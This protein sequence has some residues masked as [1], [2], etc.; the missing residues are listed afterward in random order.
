MRIL[1]SNDDG[2]YARGIA[3][4][5]GELSRTNE[6][7]VVAPDME[8]SGSSHSVTYQVPL[9]ASPISLDVLPG[10]STAIAVTGTPA[11]CVKLGCCNLVDGIELVVSGINHGSNLGTDVLYSGTVS[12]AMEAISLGIPAIASSIESNHPKHFETAAI[13]TR[14]AVEYLKERPLEP[15]CLLNINVP[16]LPAD[17][18]KG[19]RYTGL[20]CSVDR[21]P[22]VE[23]VDPY[24]RK[25]YWLPGR[26]DMPEPMK[27]SDAYWVKRGYVTLT[28]LRTHMVQQCDKMDSAQIHYDFLKEG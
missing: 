8:R 10:A 20:N 7:T 22:Y 26:A 16:D 27:D 25:Y 28:I 21:R 13:V 19:A 14:N 5:C 15:G 6:V 11:D 4:L 9:L 2:I 18:I 1:V 12:A 24:G 17:Q 3:A 23:R